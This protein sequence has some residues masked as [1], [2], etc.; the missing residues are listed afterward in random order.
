MSAI[1]ILRSWHAFTI[2]LDQDATEVAYA[3]VYFVRLHLPPMDHIGIKRVGSGQIAQRTR[4]VKIGAEID[5]YPVRS[6][7]ISES[8]NLAQIGDIQD[9]GIGIDTVQNETVDAD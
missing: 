3:E 7:S 9:G 5:F 2:G 8:G 6:E 1:V 4:C